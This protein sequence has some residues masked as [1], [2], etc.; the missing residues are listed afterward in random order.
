VIGLVSAYA[1]AVA[2]TR[3]RDEA[4][5]SPKGESTLL[6]ISLRLLSLLS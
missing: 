4:S 1:G 3:V 5:C 2:N 6:F